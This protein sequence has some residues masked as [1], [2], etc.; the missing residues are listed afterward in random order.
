MEW[1]PTRPPLVL[2][3]LQALHINH[4]LAHLR[5]MDAHHRRRLDF[6]AI[7]CARPVWP[8]VVIGESTCT[9]VEDV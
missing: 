4:A 2:Y 3:K 9:V 7:D 6:M 5:T 8:V 1:P